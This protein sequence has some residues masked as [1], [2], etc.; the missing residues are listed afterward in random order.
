V[1]LAGYDENTAANDADNV[2]SIE[3]QMAMGQSNFSGATKQVYRYIYRYMKQVYRY[4][5]RYI[6]TH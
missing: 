3:L 4:I 6:Y 5:C 1:G 2:I